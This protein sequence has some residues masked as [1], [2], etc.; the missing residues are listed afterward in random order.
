MRLHLV[1][2]AARPRPALQVMDF[3][4]LGVM[5]F[6][7]LGALIEQVRDFNILL[8]QVRDFSRLGVLIERPEEARLAAEAAPSPLGGGGTP[9]PSPG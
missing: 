9:S 8:Q 1:G 7:R 3:N 4:R 2:A 5:N 6:N